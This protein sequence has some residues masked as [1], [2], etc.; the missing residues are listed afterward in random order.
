MI[1]KEQLRMIQKMRPTGRNLHGGYIY[2]DEEILFQKAMVTA[3]GRLQ[4]QMP[5]LSPCIVDAP[6]GPWPSQPH[7]HAMQPPE[8]KMWCR[9]DSHEGVSY[10]G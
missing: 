4:T 7:P 5:A 10:T 9:I 2:M 8:N 1:E 6:S 3:Q